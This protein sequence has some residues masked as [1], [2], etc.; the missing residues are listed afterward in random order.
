MTAAAD[1][2]SLPRRVRRELATVRAMIDLYCKKQHAAAPPRCAECDELWRYAEQRVLRCPF[3]PD[4]PTC[5][6]CPVHCYRPAM[7]E[8]IRKVMRFAGP[9]MTT[10]HP[11]LAL[12]HLLDGRR[13]PPDL[14]RRRATETPPSVAGEQVEVGVE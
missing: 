2:R 9:R 8:R 14:P 13:P 5:V 1:P 10:R 11:I 7:R 6:H 4:K 3:C 12:L